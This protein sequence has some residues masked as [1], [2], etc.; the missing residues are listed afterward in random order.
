MLEHVQAVALRFDQVRV[1]MR[2][3]ARLAAERLKETS[4]LSVLRTYKDDMEAVADLNMDT[5]PRYLDL[6]ESFHWAI[7]DLAKSPMLRRTLEHVQLS[8]KP[9]QNTRPV[10]RD[11]KIREAARGDPHASR[12]AQELDPGLHPTLEV[13]GRQQPLQKLADRRLGQRADELVDDFAV[14]Y[15]L[16]GRDTPDREFA[17]DPV[18]L[19]SS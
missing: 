16:D 4:E 6:N 2:A 10:L 9:Q 17:R 19:R 3:R 11:L 18:Q 15:R 12:T 1:R 7:V 5:F 13:L 14:P 8:R